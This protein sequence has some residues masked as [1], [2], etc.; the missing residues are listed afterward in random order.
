MDSTRVIA[1]EVEQLAAV[2]GAGDDDRFI[3][4]EGG[5][6][7]EK[8]RGQKELGAHVGTDCRPVSD[9]ATDPLRINICSGRG[10]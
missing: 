5:Q 7:G 1:G 8:G 10:K 6:G 3:I 4:R 2:A 9:T